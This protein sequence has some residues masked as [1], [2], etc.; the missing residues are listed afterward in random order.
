MEYLKTGR[1]NQREIENID[2]GVIFATGCL[3]LEKVILYRISRNI[4]QATN[5]RIQSSRMLRRAVW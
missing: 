4:T 5:S 2:T 3:I 1:W